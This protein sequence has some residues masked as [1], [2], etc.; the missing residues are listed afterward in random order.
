M[1]GLSPRE[2]RARLDDIIA[3]GELE[4]FVD[5]K[6][7]NFSSGMQ[8]RLAFSVMV[9]SDPD[10]LLIDEV[11]AVGDAA[12]QQK[13]IDVFYRLRAEGKTIVLVTHEMGLVERFCHRAMMLSGG[14][15]THMGDPAEVGRAYLSENFAGRASGDFAAE[16]GAEIRLIDAWM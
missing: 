10:V 14:H 2:T 9:Q 7:K 12:F 1:M 5:Q 6:L 8:V 15:I 3:F 4:R 11:L 16:S 13:C